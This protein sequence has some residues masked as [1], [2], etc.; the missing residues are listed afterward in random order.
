MCV[1]LQ[2]LSHLDK[3]SA[4]TFFRNNGVRAGPILI[5]LACDLF[6]NTTKLMTQKRV[7]KL[8]TNIQK[9]SAKQLNET[10]V[11]ALSGGAGHK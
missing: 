9:P 4:A 8:V 6:L 5:K 3:A 10:N 1:D 2:T 7:I 11:F